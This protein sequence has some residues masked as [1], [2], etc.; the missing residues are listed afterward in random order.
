[1][2]TM[3]DYE[4]ARE[5]AISILDNTFLRMIKDPLY[6]GIVIGKAM[7]YMSLN[8]ITF[9]EYEFYSNAVYGVI[10]GK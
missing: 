5:L 7:A 4:D 10:Y 9:D 3:F 8:V 6:M 1:M 2:T